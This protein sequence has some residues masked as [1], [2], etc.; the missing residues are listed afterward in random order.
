VFCEYAVEL[1]KFSAQIRLKL[2]WKIATSVPMGPPLSSTF[3]FSFIIEL[4]VSQAGY[5]VKVIT[6]PSPDFANLSKYPFT[7]FNT[8]CGHD[9]PSPVEALLINI[10]N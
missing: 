9:L 4:A 2:T 7:L 3:L 6:I 1:T 5:I 10:R 8:L